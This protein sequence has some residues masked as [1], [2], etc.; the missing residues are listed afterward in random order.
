MSSPAAKSL[1]MNIFSR[2]ICRFVEF[3]A[4]CTEAEA[5]RMR[6]RE[7]EDVNKI[8]AEMSASFGFGALV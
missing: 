2:M 4:L 5:R 8:K 7:N 3:F 6:G 1:V